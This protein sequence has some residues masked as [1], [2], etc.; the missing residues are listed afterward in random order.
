MIPVFPI[1][2]KVTLPSVRDLLRWWP[3]VLIAFLVTHLAYIGLHV[4]Q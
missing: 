1:R 4:A 3:Y 2:A